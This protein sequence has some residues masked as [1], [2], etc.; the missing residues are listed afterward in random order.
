M[1]PTS[2]ESLRWQ[3]AGAHKTIVPKCERLCLERFLKKRFVHDR[4]IIEQKDCF[5]VLQVG[6]EEAIVG[7]VGKETSLG[8]VFEKRR[9]KK[10]RLSCSDLIRI[11]EDADDMTDGDRRLIKNLPTEAPSTSDN[12]EGE[13]F[14]HDLCSYIRKSNLYRNEGAESNSSASDSN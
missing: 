13:V 3:P 14:F 1:E 10:V 8:E 5:L 11:F 12:D 2:V 9:P 6:D 4:T 7:S